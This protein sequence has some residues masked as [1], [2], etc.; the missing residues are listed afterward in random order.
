M[1]EILRVENLCTE[2]RGANGVVRAVDGVDLTLRRGEILGLV[3][4]SGSGKSVTGYSILGLIDP[5]GRVTA[6][7]VLFAGAD[8]RTLDAQAMRSIRGRRIAMV[9]QD[10]MSTL[11][12][13]LR[14]G[15]QMTDT[16]HAHQ[17]LTRRAARARAVQAL[18][19]VGIPS[20]ADRML[21]YP[22]QLSGGMRQRVAIAI[23]L[24]NDPDIIIA[25]EPTT[26]LDVTIQAQ[27]LAEV[28]KL[29]AQSGTALIWITHDLGVVANLADSIAVMYAGAIVE[30]GEARNVLAAPAH[31]YTHG[32]LA[33]VPA[34]NR[35]ERRLPQIPGS[36]ASAAEAPGCRFQPRCDRATEGCTIAPAMRAVAPSQDVRCVHPMANAAMPLAAER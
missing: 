11:H 20:P 1:L 17:S 30:Y 29:V 34:R 8:L 16:L 12:P 32:L 22:H 28:Q 13:M 36:I 2:F 26:G 18:E 7:R 9:F 10:P 31:P 24:L 23:A 15:T 3:G 19:R 27:I 6:G 25:D 35:D 4:E 21:A 33:S 5:P 14:I